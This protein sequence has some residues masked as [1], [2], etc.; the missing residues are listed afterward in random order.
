MCMDS[1]F[2]ARKL[3]HQEHGTLGHVKAKGSDAGNRLSRLVWPGTSTIPLSMFGQ[4]WPCIPLFPE[5]V[6]GH[7][8][9]HSYDIITDDSH[10]TRRE[11]QPQKIRKHPVRSSNGI[12]LVISEHGYALSHGAR[13]SQPPRVITDST[14]TFA[15]R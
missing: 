6:A 15:A 3:P 11:H 14:D 9:F 10:S 4:Q 1:N 7:H 2:F 13:I 8:I 12:I 5:E